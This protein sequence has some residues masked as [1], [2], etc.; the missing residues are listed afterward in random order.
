MYIPAT[1]RYSLIL[2]TQSYKKTSFCCVYFLILF[3]GKMGAE[4][5]R[6]VLTG[7]YLGVYGDTS[8]V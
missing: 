1:L 8:T 4:V 3:N 7:C 6:S 5:C 2:T